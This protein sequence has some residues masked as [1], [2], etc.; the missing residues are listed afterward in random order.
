MVWQS[1]SGV[2]LGSIIACSLSLVLELADVVIFDLPKPSS[3]GSSSVLDRSEL[4]ILLIA[5]TI[6]CF[7]NIRLFI[8]NLGLIEIIR[9]QRRLGI[10][11]VIT[12]VLV[13]GAFLMLVVLFRF[14]LL[15]MLLLLPLL[16][17]LV[18]L[19]TSFCSSS[20]SLIRLDTMA[21]IAVLFR[22]TLCGQLL[23]FVVLVALTGLATASLRHPRFCRLLLYLLRCL[24]DQLD[25]LRLLVSDPILLFLVPLLL[26]L[27]LLQLELAGSLR[28]PTLL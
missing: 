5:K 10:L 23:V 17:F 11:H 7:H 4:V 27:L 16:V 28:L 3:L 13:N 15:E 9:D 25:V 12:L 21:K 24:D 8:D 2:E 20:L 22:R 6:R 26:F 1:Q 14:I 18:L 19:P